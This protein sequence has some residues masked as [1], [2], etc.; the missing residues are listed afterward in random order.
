MNEIIAEATHDC[1]QVHIQTFYFED[2]LIRM[3]SR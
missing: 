2:K 3:L 1:V